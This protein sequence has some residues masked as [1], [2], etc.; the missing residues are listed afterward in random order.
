MKTHICNTKGWYFFLFI[1]I[2]CNSQ[3]KTNLKEK[4]EIKRLSKNN[5]SQIAQYII[6]TF[7]DSKDNLWFGTIDKGVAKYNDKELK[8]FTIK[9]GLI[10]NTITSIVE[11][12]NENLWFGTGSGL[13]KYDGKIFVNF[14]QKENNLA[15]RISDLLIDSKGNFWIGTWNGVYLFNG[16]SFTPFLIPN[17]KITTVINEDTKNWITEIFE[18]S[19]G[20]IWFSRDGYGVCNFNGKHF[21]HFT[22]KDGLASNN[23]QAI[24]EDKENNIWFG[25]RV[26]E[27][28]NPNIDKRFGSGGL[29]KYDGESFTNY[30]NIEG[31]NN[32]DVFD[33]YKDSDN[34]IWIGTTNKGAY[35]YNGKSFVNYKFNNIK[36]LPTYAI[37]NILQD[38]NGIFWFG[39]SGGLF[40][41]KKSFIIN[42]NKE[43]LQNK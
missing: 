1:I 11:D 40:K 41:L 35:K 12:N 37:Q 25:S 31:L 4:E 2:S 28:D 8:Y 19:K 5:T 17:P 29:T 14:T 7:E 30:S 39:C 34:N 23:V 43:L 38:K 32:S 36:N 24:L 27:R 9:D 42:I 13:S 16:N 33:I 18:D 10:G 21:T 20:N 26:S 6:E 3:N 22:K 15:N